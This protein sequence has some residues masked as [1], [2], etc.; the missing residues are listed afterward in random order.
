MLDLGG[1]VSQ[2]GVEG[3]AQLA[4][5]DEVDGRRGEDDGERDRRGRDDSQTGAEAHCSRRA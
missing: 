5:H 1:P 2:R 4:P 3:T